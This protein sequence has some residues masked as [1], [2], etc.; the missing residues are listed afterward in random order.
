ML[1]C[2][3]RLPNPPLLQG[4]CNTLV[5]QN[6]QLVAAVQ[7]LTAENAT[8]RQQLALVCQA[9]K[10]VAAA[11]GAA[12]KPPA[13]A[14]AAAAKPVAAA[15]KPAAVPTPAKPASVAAAAAAGAKLGQA[16]TVQA[17]AGGAATAAAAAVVAARGLQWPLLPFAGLLPKVTLPVMQRPAAQ[18]QQQ[19]PAVQ[20]A[21]VARPAPAA[22]AERA[23]KRARTAA[24]A[25]TAFLALFTLFMFSGL[26]PVPLTTPT[27]TSGSSSALAA[28]GGAQRTLQALPDPSALANGI[29]HSGRGLQALPAAGSDVGGGQLVQ[30]GPQPF[31]GP[32]TS[33]LGDPGG[34]SSVPR[35]PHL[36]QLLN[37]TL[38]ALL[39]EPDNAA[40]EAAALQRLQELGPVALLLDSDDARGGPG[41]N[42]LAASAA[43]PQLAGAVAMRWLLAVRELRGCYKLAGRVEQGACKSSCGLQG[44]LLRYACAPQVYVCKA[45]S[46]SCSLAPCPCPAGQLFGG[47]GLEVPQMCQPVLEFDASSVPHAARTRRNLERHVMGATGF[48]GRSL[49]AASGA[50]AGGPAGAAAV[51]GRPG[52]GGTAGAPALRISEEDGEGLEGP[53]QGSEGS[54]ALLPASSAAGPVLVS[55]LLPAN[56]SG[57]GSG[58]SGKLAAADKVFVVLLH[59]QERFVTYSCSLPRPVVL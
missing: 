35:G 45:T 10:G 17:T 18:Q 46:P 37:S 33:P 22:A 12:A 5:Q 38:Q 52:G 58:S 29:R 3:C 56:A 54:D 13:A 8:L 51:G 40:L 57:N 15:A 25:S 47:A 26:T 36:Q 31:V 28:A 4:R 42:P 1:R 19:R 2:T 27:S 59:P 50:A 55:I 20:P 14:A 49:A 48:R 30:H 32:A 43:F 53:E 44:Q 9:Q 6:A 39:L 21:A 7:R 16:L 34:S 24:G 23:P 11:A 41:A